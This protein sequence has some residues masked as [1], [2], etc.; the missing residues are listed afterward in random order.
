MTEDTTSSSGGSAAPIV[1]KGLFKDDF[2]AFSKQTGAAAVTFAIIGEPT[3]VAISAAATGTGAGLGAWLGAGGGA[4][5]AAAGPA[6]SSATGAGSDDQA[7]NGGS[8]NGG[9]GNGVL[10]ARGSAADRRTVSVADDMQT[11]HTIRLADWVLDAATA[12]ALVHS[13]AALTGLTTLR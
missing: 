6:A 2:V 11:P 1:A 8:S 10:D 12:T 9:V 7:N 13:A 5:N 3:A 4:G